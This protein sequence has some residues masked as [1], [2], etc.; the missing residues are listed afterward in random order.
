MRTPHKKAHAVCPWAAATWGAC[1]KAAD[2]AYADWQAMQ[3]VLL[4]WRVATAGEAA[5]KRYRK[6]DGQFAQLVRVVAGEAEDIMNDDGNPARTPWV[7]RLR[8]AIE[9]VKAGDL[10]AYTLYTLMPPQAA[11]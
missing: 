1:D 2:S 11:T 6:D 10:P 8:A 5:V 4:A 9:R 7:Q 3:Q